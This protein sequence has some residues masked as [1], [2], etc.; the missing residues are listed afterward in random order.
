[1]T[2]INITTINQGE[3]SLQLTCKSGNRALASRQNST[4][5]SYLHKKIKVL[6]LIMVYEA[7]TGTFEQQKSLHASLEMYVC[8]QI[9]LN[10]VIHIF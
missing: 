6:G 1:M 2:S 4:F 10:Y 9:L 5:F 8:E 3:V 7:I